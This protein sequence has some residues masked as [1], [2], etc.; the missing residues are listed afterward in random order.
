MDV[1]LKRTR[2]VNVGL[3]RYTSLAASADR[4]RLVAT[5]ADSRSDLWRVTVGGD[6]PPRSGPDTRRACVPERLRTP[7]RA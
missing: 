6:G 7:F 5:V 4:T 3:E 2:R 1:P